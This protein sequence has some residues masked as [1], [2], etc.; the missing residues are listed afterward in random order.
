MYSWSVCW[1]CGLDRERADAG[2]KGLEGLD[3]HTVDLADSYSRGKVDTHNAQNL[4]PNVSRPATA[5]PLDG[6]QQEDTRQGQRKTC[7]Y[8]YW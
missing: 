7:G 8:G 3:T 4:L 2:E 6:K 1:S 5:D